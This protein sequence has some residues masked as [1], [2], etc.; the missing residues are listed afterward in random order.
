M[1]CQGLCWRCQGQAISSFG[2]A[3]STASVRATSL[4]A[5][6]VWLASEAAPA[7][8]RPLPLARVLPEAYLVRERAQR[9]AARRSLGAGA[10]SGGIA[11]A[12][13]AVSGDG[14]PNEEA[15][16]DSDFTYLPLLPS[17]L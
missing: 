15:V 8:A 5:Y 14:A 3:K 16:T 17:N 10:A 13:S 2:N 7:G 1:A 11:G 4:R 6:S 12:G 9:D